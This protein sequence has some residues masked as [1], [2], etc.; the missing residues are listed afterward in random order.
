LEITVL[1]AFRWA[2]NCGRAN[3]IVGRYSLAIFARNQSCDGCGAPSFTSV[4]NGDIPPLFTET[5]GF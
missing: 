2:R 1:C 5:V 3:V 4:E